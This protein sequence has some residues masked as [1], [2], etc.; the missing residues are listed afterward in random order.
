MKEK[1]ILTFK[2]Q[3]SSVILR[4][5]YTEGIL[6]EVRFMD[7]DTPPDAREWCLARVPVRTEIIPELCGKTFFADP[8]PSEITF[9]AFWEDYGNKQNKDRA[10]KFWMQLNEEDKIAALRAIPRYNRYLNMKP[11]IE[12]KYP[13]TWLKNR[14]WNDEYK[15]K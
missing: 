8:E 11:N 5:S 10:Y 15:V 13:D 9:A 3:Q 7:A 6:E 4:A 12:K 2:G 14:C 1:Y